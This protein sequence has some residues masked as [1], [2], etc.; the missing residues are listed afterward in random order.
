[1]R[2]CGTIHVDARLRRGRLLWMRRHQN[3]PAIAGVG[4]SVVRT[5]EGRAVD[6]LPEGQPC[7]SVHTQ[8]SPGEVLRARTPQ[9]DVLAQETR[10]TRPTRSKLDYDRHGV[11]INDDDK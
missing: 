2:R 11:D 4:P 5:L 6:H 1:M 7:A 8:V 3:A 9:D 10:A